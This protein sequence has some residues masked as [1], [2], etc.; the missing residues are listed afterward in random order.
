MCVFFL[1][2]KQFFGVLVVKQEKRFIKAETKIKKL[3]KYL[4]LLLVHGFADYKKV[5]V[6]SRRGEGSA[7][8]LITFRLLLLF[9]L[10]K[11]N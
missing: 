6:I 9:L 7:T 3:G 11:T 4:I 2:I 1:F 10:P 8:F 5:E